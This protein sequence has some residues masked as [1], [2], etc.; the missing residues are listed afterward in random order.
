MVDYSDVCVGGKEDD[1]TPIVV[2][3]DECKL[4]KSILKD[5]DLTTSM[6]LMPSHS[7]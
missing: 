7:L 5:Y 2:E 1:G 4:V 6:S 3:L